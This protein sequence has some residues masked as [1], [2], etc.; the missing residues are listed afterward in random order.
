MRIEILLHLLIVVSGLFWQESKAEDFIVKEVSVFEVNSAITPATL[1]YL[2]HQFPKTSDQAIILIKINTPGGLVTTTKEIITLIGSQNKPTVVWITPEGAS[3][4]SAGA[5]IASAAHF[6]VMSPGTN[7]GAATPV[8]LGEDIKESD[9]RSKALNDLTSLVRSLSESRGRPG[10][11]F[12]EMIKTA[13]SFTDKEALEQKM[14][15]GIV[16]SQ[17]DILPLLEGK[18]FVLKGKTLTIRV[19]SGAVQNEYRASMGQNLLSVLANPQTAYFLFLLGVALI[20]F[21]FQAPGGFVAGGVGITSLIFAAISFQ[22]LPLDWGAFGLLLVGAVLLILEIY[23]TSYGL[24]AVGGLISFLAGSL[25]LFHDETGYISVDYPVII[26]TLLGVV[27]STGFIIWY[28]LKEAKKQPKSK[29]F[30]LPRE[31]TGTIVTIGTNIDSPFH[32]QVKVQG[33]IWKGISE[34]KLAVG[35]RVI[36][37]DIAPEQLLVKIKKTLKE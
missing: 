4:S 18:V 22:V 23:V 9:G 14:I 16:S 28:I 19:D 1:D 34:E 31:S 5:I 32:Y 15:S 13:K 26:S 11:P 21:E 3:A 37:I 24:L 2:Q 35:E 6:I 33:E 25:F 10:A 27:A 12:E 30:F 29:D 36:I 8:G 17:K 20:Y 7:M